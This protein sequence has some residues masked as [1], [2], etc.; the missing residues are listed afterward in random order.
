VQ[1]AVQLTRRQWELVQI[2][3]AAVVKASEQRSVMFNTILAGAGIAEAEVQHVGQDKHGNA[4]LVVRV[5]ITAPDPGKPP[6]K[7][8]RKRGK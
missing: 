3:D 6:A 1:H 7:A 4:F 5:P 8:P 2:A